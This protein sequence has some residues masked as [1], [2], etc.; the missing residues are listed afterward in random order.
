[1]DWLEGIKTVGSAVG[2]AAL[3]AGI[4]S[5]VGLRAQHKKL[6]ELESFKQNSA[7]ETFRYTKIYEA[8]TE[9]QS[10]PGI[11]YLKLQDNSPER[12][13]TYGKVGERYERLKVIFLRV[14][15]LLDPELKS[16]SLKL[17]K[18]NEYLFREL[19]VGLDVAGLHGEQRQNPISETQLELLKKI[20]VA[21]ID[22]E[23]AI[24]NSLSLSLETLT[25]RSS[26]TPQKRGAP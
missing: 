19:V 18:E 3:V 15:P 22:A 5:L 10:Y 2:F 25:M 26:G 11:S 14:A 20:L 6:L 21:Q 8:L 17:L 23:E 1:M 16:E 4:F 12:S 9:V 7:L 24:I 13:E